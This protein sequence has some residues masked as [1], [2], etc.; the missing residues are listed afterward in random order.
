MNGSIFNEPFIEKRESHDV[1]HRSVLAAHLDFHWRDLL[2]NVKIFQPV[3]LRVDHR[4]LISWRHSG[5]LVAE[6]VS[7]Y[8]DNLPDKYSSWISWIGP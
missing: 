3:E 1:W 2:I 6:C 5:L 7:R 4:H 8:L